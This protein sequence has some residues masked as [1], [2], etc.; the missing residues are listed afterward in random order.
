[1]NGEF[2]VGSGG[3]GGGGNGNDPLAATW[4]TAPQQRINGAYLSN[5]MAVEAL[6]A[7]IKAFYGQGPKF[8]YM[9]GCSIGGWATLEEAERFPEDFDGYSVGAPPVYQT[10]HD[11]GFWH[12]WEW[13]ANQRQ[14]GSII[15]ASDK[16]PIL[17][18]AALQRCAA[19]SGLIDG[20]L[21]QPLA[22]KFDKSWVQCPEGASDTS[23]CLTAEEAKVAEQLYLGPNGKNFFEVGGFPLGSELQW[24]LST[25]GKLADGEALAPHGIHQFLMPPLSGEDTR[26]IMASFSISQEWF[27][28][29]A[30]MQPL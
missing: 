3:G 2:A 7:T 24:H 17:H 5:H 10:T 28:K 15:L 1:M 11:L 13:R 16:L 8:S 26:T 30:E 9:T 27:D 21:Q 22:C 29:T 25:P 20:D 23:K 14:D 19:V 6:K 18:A 4:G 12:G